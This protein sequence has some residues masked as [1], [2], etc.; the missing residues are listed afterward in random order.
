MKKNAA[1]GPP[2]PERRREKVLTVS[3]RPDWSERSPF[4]H[5][6]TTLNGTTIRDRG[7]GHRYYRPLQTTAY[8]DCRDRK[9]V[10]DRDHSQNSACISAGIRLSNGIVDE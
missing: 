9:W 4:R 2:S 8:I 10:N 1:P 7:G 3:S 6:E 5:L